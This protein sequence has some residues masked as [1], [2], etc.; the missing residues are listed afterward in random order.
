MWKTILALPCILLLFSAASLSA[1]GE[2]GAQLTFA[3]D[4]HDCGTIDYED[5]DIQTIAIPFSNTGDAPLVIEKVRGCCGTRITDWPRKPVL[6]GETGEIELQ[7]RVADRPQM[8]RRVITVLSND[9]DA[10]RQRFRITGRVTGK[11]E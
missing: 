6:P 7:F 3:N 2:Q 8:I 11:T 10:P 9:S 1:E 4:R 5:V